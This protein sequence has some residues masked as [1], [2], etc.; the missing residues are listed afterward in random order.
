MEIKHI[1]FDLDRTLWDFET[2][3]HITLLNL[4]QEFSLLEKGVDSSEEFIKKYN[5]HNEKLWHLYREGRIT[6]ENL[7]SKRFLLVLEEYGISDAELADQFGI[8]YIRQSPL[9]TALFPFTMQVMKYLSKRYKLHIITNGFEEVQK[10][11]EYSLELSSIDLSPYNNLLKKMQDLKIEIYDSKNE[12]QHFSNHYQKLEKLIWEY[13]QDEPIQPGDTYTRDPFSKWLKNQKHYEDNTYGI[14][15]IAVKDN[16]YIGST[17]LRVNHKSEPF[18]AYTL[19]MGVLKVYRRQGVAT[20]LK[21]K[22]IQRLKEKG[23]TEIRTGNEE[24]NPMFQINEKLGFKPM[25]SSIEFRKD[26]D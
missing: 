6:K 13:I 26:I 24:N 5:F 18:K 4:V 3:S 15:M 1:F 2:N 19:G 21:V 8:E 25:P 20:A 10:Y 23:I 9:K 12:M 7:R 11:R 14:E 17:N 16:N 22:A